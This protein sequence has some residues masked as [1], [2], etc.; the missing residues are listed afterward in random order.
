MFMNLGSVAKLV[1][2]IHHMTIVNIHGRGYILIEVET[3][4]RSSSV[5][6]KQIEPFVIWSCFR[7]VG[8]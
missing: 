5:P 2:D 4:Q 6:T 8:G 3:P 1:V 7:V